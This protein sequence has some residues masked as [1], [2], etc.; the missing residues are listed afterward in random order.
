MRNPLLIGDKV[1]LRPLEQ[2]DGPALVGWMN[3]KGD[4]LLPFGAIE[5]MPSRRC[6]LL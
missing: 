6:A 5:R 1:F 2:A 4:A 3:A